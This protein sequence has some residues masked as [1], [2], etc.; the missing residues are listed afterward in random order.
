MAD[1]KS[2]YVTAS[3]V[4]ITLAS[5][6]N[7]A[8]RQSDAIDNTANL[9]LDA[10]VQL[11]VKTGTTVSGDLQVLVYAYAT[12]GSSGLGY[13]GGASGSDSAFSGTLD[14]TKLIGIIS[15]PAAATAYESDLMSVAAAFGGVL[16]GEWG[17]IVENRTGSALDSA[18]ANHVKK[19]VGVLAQSV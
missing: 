4:T 6:A 8:T 16:P 17:I 15:T 10:L 12:V 2:K 18:E 14:N 11:K 7:G 9:Y 1:I 3:D 19:Y 5:L 13:S